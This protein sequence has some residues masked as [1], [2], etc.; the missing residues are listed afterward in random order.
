M[1]GLNHEMGREL[2]WNNY[3]TDQRC[4]CFRQFWD[5]RGYVREPGDPAD[6][7]ALRE[8]LKDI[9]PIHTWPRPAP[10]GQH[11]NRPGTD[12][13]VLLVRGELFK[14]YPNAVIY[15]GAAK[16]DPVHR[17]HDLADAEKHPLYR[18][19]LAPDITFFGFDLTKEEVLG[20]THDHNDPNQGWFFVFQQ[21][22]GEPRFGL[23]PAPAPATAHEWNDLSWG[24][25]A[26]DAPALDAVEQVPLGPLHGGVAID[27]TADHP[28][29]PGNAWGSDA[30]QMAYILLR[31]PVR[32][33]VHA[34]T[35]LPH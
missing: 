13:L 4:S 20:N 12:K 10:L 28:G 3:P 2:L 24:N 34:E 23:E 16:W 7:Q 5:V 19:T 22:P 29:D 14:R 18:G 1:V 9:P 26:A 25:L 35:M 8:K 27:G 17:R 15:A 33:A 21:Q 30:A 32:I 31:R 6:D 11:R